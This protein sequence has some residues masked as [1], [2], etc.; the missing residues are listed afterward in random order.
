[1]SGENKNTG[2]AAQ[3]S[4]G[5]VRQACRQFAMLYFNLCRTLVEAL[6]EEA[7]F[8]LVQKTIFHLAL[9]R[10]D[11]S[12][13]KALAQDLVPSLENFPL[14]NDL[15]FI[16]WKEWK[17]EDGGV[18]CPYAEAWLGYYEVY[19]WFKRFASMYC[20]VIDTTNIENFSRTTSHRI[21]RNLLWGDLSCEREYFESE[22]IKRGIFTYGERDNG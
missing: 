6:G 1:M 18:R 22:K 9:D 11:R 10:T 17:P 15:P 3:P 12:R 2:P 8:P 19:P 16:A 21:T 5:D 7:A 14:V 13:A 20:D 4:L